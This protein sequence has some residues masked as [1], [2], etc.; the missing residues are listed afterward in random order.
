MAA[1]HP[2][3]DSGNFSRAW[4]LLPQARLTAG[5]LCTLA[6]Y[7]SL[8]AP[9]LAVLGLA[10]K[11]RQMSCGFS[12]HSLLAWMLRSCLATSHIGFAAYC[13]SKPC[14]F[15]YFFLWISKLDARAADKKDLKEAK[16]PSNCLRGVKCNLLAQVSVADKSQ[17]LVAWWLSSGALRAEGFRPSG[18]S[19][20]FHVLYCLCS[21]VSL[22]S[23]THY[24]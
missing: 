17:C 11:E 13:N 15:V 6:T 24:Q 1:P 19:H 22:A 14:L 4:F 9:I 23:Q 16:G 18:C 5:L 21:W 10:F 7:L 8:T 3:R 2:P 20:S 12:C